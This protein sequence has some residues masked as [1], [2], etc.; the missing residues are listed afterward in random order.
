MGQIQRRLA[1]VLALDVVSYSTLSERDEEDTHRRVRV[2][3]KDSVE[4]KIAEA[5]GRIIKNTG[6]GMIVE[7]ASA[8]D[9]IRS[10]IQ[11]Q[12]VNNI[13]QFGIAEERKIRLRI[14]INLSDV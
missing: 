8:V 12:D 9:S 3:F 13:A 11:I 14:G 2:I 4:P 5:G 1:A 10:A 7:F 6:D